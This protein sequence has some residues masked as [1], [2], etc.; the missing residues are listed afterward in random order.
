MGDRALHASPID[1][2]A[3]THET[4]ARQ[5]DHRRMVGLASEGN[6]VHGVF[7]EREDFGGPADS[8]AQSTDNDAQSSNH[9]EELDEGEALLLAVNTFGWLP[10]A[11]QQCEESPLHG[12]LLRG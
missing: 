7:N 3:A 1:V 9:N 4:G 8:E 5:E 11:G 12:F 2:I 10:R 6:S